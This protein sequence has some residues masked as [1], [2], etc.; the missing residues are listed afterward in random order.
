VADRG[1]R[2]EGDER[3]K[4]GGVREKEVERGVR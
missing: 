1:G 2:E 3:G 4:R